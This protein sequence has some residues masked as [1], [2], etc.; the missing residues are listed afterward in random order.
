MSQENVEVIRRAFDAFND[1]NR[2]AFLD[3]YDDDI[4]LR[5]GAF[6]IESGSYYGAEAVEHQYTRL[7]APFGA[8]YRVEVDELIEVGDSTVVI[9]RA[10]ARGQRSGAEV[11]AS[12][13]AIFT[14]R[15][16]KIIRIDHLANRD[17]ALEA[18][19]LTE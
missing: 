18:M 13:A 12:Q 19:G 6:S 3:L 16:G 4:V 8:T 7:F 1:G 10:R 5:I 2:A 14:M 9:H 17:E 15:G 11:V